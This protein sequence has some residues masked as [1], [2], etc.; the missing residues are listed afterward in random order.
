[1]SER[2]LLQ[3]LDAIPNDI[4]RFEAVCQS[5]ADWGAIF[6][7]AENH[8][9]QALLNH[10]LVEH[11][12]VLAPEAAARARHQAFLVSATQTGALEPL[13]ELVDALEAERVPAVAL[14]G[15]A[16]A[17]RLYPDPRLRPSADLDLLVRD[18]DFERASDVA[19]RFGYALTDT[20]LRSSYHRRYHFHVSYY[21][22]G[23]PLLELHFL[24]VRAFGSELESEAMI[25][26]SRWHATSLGR[27]VRVPE[28]EDEALYLILHFTHH[29]VF[30]LK[31]L[32]DVKLHMSRYPELDWALVA[33]RAREAK[34]ERG[35]LEGV[36]QFNLR[37]PSSPI[38]VERGLDVGRRYAV[39]ALRSAMRGRS[40]TGKAM[41][42]GGLVYEGLL[43]DSP[44]GVAHHF[45]RNAILIARRRLDRLR[46]QGRS[47]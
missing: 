40:A 19:K 39:D 10:Y 32:F 41:I 35:F 30:S 31:W 47:Q 42:V 37:F 26:R 21:R 23:G 6:A 38:P 44:L 43:G 16:L 36:R 28:P 34:L 7:A 25:E 3:L 27:S 18:A 2:L 8:G 15:P 13:H 5:I 4:P 24:G 1:V 9:L 33:R 22:E 11:A 20:E 12:I 45:G 17:E 46:H 29:F 14:K